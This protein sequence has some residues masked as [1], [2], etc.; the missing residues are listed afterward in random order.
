M[1][2]FIKRDPLVLQADEFLQVLEN[3][4]RDIGEGVARDFIHMEHT[5]CGMKFTYGVRT[6]DFEQRGVDKEFWLIM[7]RGTKG[8]IS[9]SFR[10]TDEELIEAINV[11]LNW[12]IHQEFSTT[13][14]T[15]L[16]AALAKEASKYE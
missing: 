5:H 7:T 8:S 15:E 10:S 13:N 14:H 9:A 2:L 4:L 1:N 16:T 3:S 11:T 6:V 12:L